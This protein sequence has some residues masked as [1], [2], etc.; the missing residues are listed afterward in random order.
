[1]F[2]AP[3]G[4][5]KTTLAKLIVT[6]LE[7]KRGRVMADGVNLAQMAPAWWRKQI[8][9]MPQEPEFIAGTL[10]E[11]IVMLNPELP[12]EKLNEILKTADLRSFLDRTPEGLETP[13]TDNEKNFPPG[14]RRRISLARALASEG[15][16]ALLDEPT[17]ALD[18]K[19]VEAV[20]RVMNHLARAGKTIV[21]F[22]NDPKILK[23]TGMILNLNRK[24]VP[25]LI[26]KPDQPG[27]A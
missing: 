22:T 13:V 1:M 12:Q 6:L 10:R 7:P 17:D 14:I 21:V 4:C 15:R 5:G 19:G 25:E 26:R 18:Q 11:N 24:P 2:V 3:K 23:G 9:Y 27:P 8:I 20:Y 16:L